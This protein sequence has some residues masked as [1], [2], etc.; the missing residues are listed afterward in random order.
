MHD[1]GGTVVAP[2]ETAEQLAAAVMPPRDHLALQLRA[3]EG[4]PGRGRD[5][6]FAQDAREWHV[7]QGG[8]AKTE[9]GH[10]RCAVDGG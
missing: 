4:M 5:V 3:A 8:Q 1:M 6:F 7:V 10:D 9:A 2:G